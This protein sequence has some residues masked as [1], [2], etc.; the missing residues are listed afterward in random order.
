MPNPITRDT[1]GFTY[2]DTN[3]SWGQFFAP[4]IHDAREEVVVAREEVV[5]ACH[6]EDACLGGVN[7]SCAP[8]YMD[9]RYAR[10]SFG[11]SSE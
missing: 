10:A 2:V 4:T 1:T 3:S 9:N 8:G 6:I 5:V 11:K 7:A